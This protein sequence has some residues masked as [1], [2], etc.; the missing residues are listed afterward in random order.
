MFDHSQLAMA[1]HPVYRSVKKIV[2]E[3][4]SPTYEKL[5]RT[6]QPAERFVRL[7]VTGSPKTWKL[8]W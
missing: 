3:S 8:K 2:F 5:F 4:P 1:L 6:S 7:F